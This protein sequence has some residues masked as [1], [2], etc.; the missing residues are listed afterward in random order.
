MRKLIL[1]IF[2]AML[3]LNINLAAFSGEG[4]GTEED[5]YQ[6][7]NVQQLQEMKD[8]LKAHYILMNDID[9]SETRN[10]ND[11]KGFKPIGYWDFETNLNKGFQGFLNGNSYIIYDLFISRSDEDCIGLFGFV[12][13]NSGFHNLGLVDC[14]I[15]GRYYVGS[16]AGILGWVY[17]H[18][19]ISNCYSTGN[20]TGDTVVGGFCA[21][22]GD[23]EINDCYTHCNVT[24]IA[25]VGGFIG[26]YFSGIINNCYSSGL[27]D[28]IENLGGFCPGRNQ[29]NNLVDNSYWDI[30]TS[31]IDSS[32]GSKGK[33]TTEMMT[34]ATYE[35]WDFDSVW[36]MVEGKTY[37]HLRAL[38]DCDNLL[39]VEEITEEIEVSVYPN[40]FSELLIT[41]YELRMPGYVSLKLYDVLGNEVAVLVNEYQ[42]AG[43]YNFELGS[44]NYELEA[45]VY[46]YVFNIADEVRSGK[47]VK[48]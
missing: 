35:G 32:Y 7:T 6:I 37:P 29:V 36:C 40:P 43:E 21:L 47:I 12:A 27:V 22:T 46:Y 3:C 24:G 5:P 25:N 10:W 9:G 15:K 14:D 34:Q 30:E 17:N 4:F 39:D 8:G 44:S 1:S 45:G 28:G 23:G 33:T 31:G 26:E 16:F 11:G 41:N 13:S 48:Y 2:I 20:V 19:K 38:E 18:Y 42:D